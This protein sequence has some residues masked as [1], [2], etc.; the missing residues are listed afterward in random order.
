M[1][2]SAHL[3]VRPATETDQVAIRAL[4]RSERLNPYGLDWPNF[5]VAVGSGGLVGAVQL[6]RHR[7]GSRELGSLV[8]RQEARRQ[9]IASRLINTLLAGMNERV[10]LITAEAFAA[11]YERWGFRQIEPAAAPAAIRR[12]YRIGSLVSV[13]RTVQ[14]PA[15][16]PTRNSRSRRKC[17][18]AFAGRINRRVRL[19]TSQPSDISRARCEAIPKIARV[20][21]GRARRPCAPGARVALVNAVPW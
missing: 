1:K 3:T 19:K 2:Q 17:A 16:P 10:L 11:R 15:H 4:V 9:G 13:Y 5:L 18:V 21:P 14:T 12:N 8:V 6:R 20:F 7:D